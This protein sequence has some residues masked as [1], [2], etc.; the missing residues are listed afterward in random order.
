MCCRGSV[1]CWSRESRTPGRDE[2]PAVLRDVRDRCG[3]GVSE[4][5]R[6]PAA[7]LVPYN[8]AWPATYYTLAADLR[9]A[10]GPEWELEHFGS[11]SVPGLVAKPV[12]D[13]AV[14]EPTSSSS[15]W[16]PSLRA[17]GWTE[18]AALAAHRAAYLV[19]GR[20]RV[21]IAHPFPPDQWTAAHVRLFAD[22]LRRHPDDRDRYAELKQRLVQDDT[23]GEPYTRA[24]R[25]FVQRVVDRAR[26]ERGLPA[27]L[28]LA[29]T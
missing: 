2:P 11:T 18:P 22:W 12:I 27:T 15:D 23:W 21:A 4:R 5:G 10:L 1:C 6:Y 29:G 16:L 26:H 20:V 19:D 8:P 25:E 7:R 9:A 14:A 13:I 24:K 28:L 3:H 17:L